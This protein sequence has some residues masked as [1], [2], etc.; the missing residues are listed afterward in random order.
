MYPFLRRL[1]CVCVALCLLCLVGCGT[2]PSSSSAGPAQGQTSSSATEEPESSAPTSSAQE[3]TASEAPGTTSSQP[4]GPAT[5]SVTIPEGYTLARIAMLLEE[6]GICGQDAFIEA[7]QQAD[8]SAYPLIAAQPEDEH[9]CFRLEGY[10]FPDTYEF[11]LDEDPTEVIT[12][13]LDNAEQRIS[14][15][16]REE[17]AAQGY[18]IDEVLTLASIIQKESNSAEVMPDVSS[19]LHNRLA[20]GMRLQCDVTI[21]Y[22]EGAIKPF[23]TG[24]ID[25]YNAYYNTYK[26]DGLPAGAICNPGL[27]AIEAA[28]APSQ[29]DYYF[30]LTDADGNYLFAEDWET[31]QQNISAAG[32]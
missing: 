7:T 18:T 31:H 29:T 23:I 20:D 8:L 22:V 16:I 4:E 12:R 26:C 3:S 28:L 10:L 15:Q 5:V 13:F 32:L 24:D 14:P 21:T 9:R 30:F 6:K 11:Y 25:R 27:D 17:A 19:V 2:Q 1:V